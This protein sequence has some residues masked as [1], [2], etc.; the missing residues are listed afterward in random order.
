[1]TKQL[2]LSAW[3]LLCWFPLARS[4][5]SRATPLINPLMPFPVTTTANAGIPLTSTRPRKA[6]LSVVIAKLPSRLLR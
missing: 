4:Q 1:M 3:L 5:L 6:W 2:K